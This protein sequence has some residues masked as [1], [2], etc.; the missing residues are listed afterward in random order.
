LNDPQV[1]LESLKAAAAGVV[2]TVADL[3][4]VNGQLS[5][6]NDNLSAANVSLQAQLDTRDQ[7][8]AAL[9][10]QID[11][12]QPKPKTV[13]DYGVK[14]DGLTDDTAALQAALDAGVRLIPDGKYLIDAT[15]SLFVR[16]GT[17]E[18]GANAVLVAKPNSAPRYY[19]LRAVGDDITVKGG[20]IVGERWAHTYTSGSTHE[21]GCGLQVSGNRITVDGAR[22]SDC[23]G[24]GIGVNGAGHVIRNV[25]STKNRRQGLSLYNCP[26][27][28]IYDSEFS[29]TG[30]AGQPDPAGLIG[31]FA[32][33]DAEPD[34]ASAVNVYCERVKCVGNRAG[35]LAWLR[36]EVGGS[37]VATLKDCV[38]EGNSNG[39]QAKALAGSITVNMS[40]CS[41]NKNSGSGC[42][43]EAGATFNIDGNTFLKPRSP[44]FTLAGT[45]SRTANDIRCVSSTSGVGKATVGTNRYV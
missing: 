6:Q 17:L 43:I 22:V 21:W 45:D 16:S 13:A 1:A 15:K 35:F 32:G 36:S 12:L 30:N 38:L 33:I 19:V 14:G 7:T 41:V 26:D 20:Q 8:I 42:R 37:I 25:V 34:K 28:K 9:K 4:L 27:L 39:A 10:A 5:L 23:T 31:P 29:N 18:M 2:Q 44:T 40:G 3:T 11:V 24:D